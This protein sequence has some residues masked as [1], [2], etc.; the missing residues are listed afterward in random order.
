MK[1]ARLS[2]NLFDFNYEREQF[3]DRYTTK[4]LDIFEAFRITYLTLITKKPKL[5]ITYLYITKGT[6]VHPNVG[7]QADDLKKDVSGLLPNAE[8]EVVFIGAEELLRGKVKITKRGNSLLRKHLYLTVAHLLS[9]HSV[10]QELHAEN[11]SA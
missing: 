8:I 4:V 11:V 10:F 5:K 6:E 7:R 2:A 3:E 9:Y 1:L